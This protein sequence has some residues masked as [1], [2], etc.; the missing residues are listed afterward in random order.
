MSEKVY[1]EMDVFCIV[2]LFFIYRHASSNLGSEQE[3]VSFKRTLLWTMILLVL[4]SLWFIGQNGL[5]PYNRLANGVVNALY[6]A[7]TGVLGYYWFSCSEERLN[8]DFHRASKWGCLPAVLLIVLALLSIRTGWLFYIDADNV[9]TR[10][11]QYWLQ[12][13]ISYIYLLFPCVHAFISGLRES[14][15]EKQQD[16]FFLAAFGAL[17]LGGGLLS[18]FVLGYPVFLACTSMGLL[19]VF[20]HWQDAQIFTD[21]LTGLNNRRRL[22]QYLD[23]L[24]ADSSNWKKVIIFLGDVDGFKQIN[25]VYGHLEGDRA[26]QIVSSALKRVCGHHNAFLARYGGDE[27]CAVGCISEKMTPEQLVKEIGEELARQMRE[28]SLPYKLSMS[29]GYSQYSPATP[30]ATR[31]IAAADAMLYEHKETTRSILRKDKN[32]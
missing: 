17:P 10:G 6:M 20:L 1:L 9:Y 7:S 27:F 21:A 8:K 19:I 16:D 12:P 2:M 26:L 24:A 23:Q 29:V 22:D 32:G 25:D 14:N 31:L 18:L 30:T 3:I 5:I 13:V 11:P 28:G 4:D 15:K